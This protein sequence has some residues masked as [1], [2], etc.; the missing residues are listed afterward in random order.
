MWDEAKERDLMFDRIKGTL[1]GVAVG[2][3]LGAPVEFMHYTD[4][5]R[6]Y[7]PVTEIMGGGW[8]GADVG[9][10]TD[11][12]AMTLAVAEGLMQTDRYK[13]DPVEKIGAEFIKWFYDAPI[14]AG[15]ACSRSIAYASQNGK[16]KAPR[17]ETWF[18]AAE[19]AHYDLGGLSGGNG[20]LMRTAPVA[21]FTKGH[22]R[23][24][25]AWDVSLMTHFDNDAAEACMLYC[26]LIAK[27]IRGYDFLTARSVV[28]SNTEYRT[29]SSPKT[30]F[31]PNPSGY[32]KDSFNTA[33]WGMA[34]NYSFEDTLIN[35]VNLGGDADTTGAIAGG[36]A[37]ARY[38]YSEIPE[39]W[40]AALDGRLKQRLDACAEA[41]GIFWKCRG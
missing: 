22:R 8:L 30:R 17:R 37:G 19:K 40:I 1:Y 12:T 2:D 18:K 41:G 3:C 24:M 34:R 39:R 36:L 9:K 7:G 38:G 20:S 11:D 31:R 16:V 5:Q 15:A 4:I 29:A 32:V 25:L 10:G 21:L 6:Q 26:G 14:G 23:D 35:V 33:L 27:L 13:D 28:I